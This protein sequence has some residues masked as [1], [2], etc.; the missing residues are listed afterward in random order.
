LIHLL[1]L[2]SLFLLPVQVRAGAVA[3]H[4]HALLQLMIDA[5]DGK[6]DHHAGN[7]DQA[8]PAAHTSVSHQPDVPAFGN[9]T[10]TFSDFPALA[11]IVLV[12]AVTSSRTAPNWPPIACWRDWL[13]AIEPP[14]PRVGRV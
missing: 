14:P 5:A 9:S 8:P 1:A 12:F 7:R 13:P 11:A 3:P 10:L 2:V 4:P 6:I